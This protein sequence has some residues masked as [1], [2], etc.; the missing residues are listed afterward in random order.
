MSLGWALRFQEPKTGPVSL[1]FCLMLATQDVSS[2]LLLPRPCL[3]AATFSAM[4]II[5]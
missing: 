3:T 5:D 1:S 2:W 4:M